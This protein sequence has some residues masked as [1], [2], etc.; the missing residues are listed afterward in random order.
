[1]RFM[2][3]GCA[4]LVAACV[5]GPPPLDNPTASP[6]AQQRGEARAL[7]Q[8]EAECA[9]QGKHAEA[10]RADGETIYECVSTH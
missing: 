4:A 10:R 7:E 3:C 1:M 2:V 8:A 9:T 6:R 5:T